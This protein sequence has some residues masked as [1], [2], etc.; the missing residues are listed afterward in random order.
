MKKAAKRSAKK[1]EQEAA[2]RGK[3]VGFVLECHR[4]GADHKVIE[5]VARTF[6]PD[7][8]RVYMCAGNKGLLFERCSR[9][10]EGLFEAERCDHVFVVWDLIPCDDEYRHAGKPSCVKERQHLLGTLRTEDQPKTVLLCITQELDSW[11]LADGAALAAVMSRPTHPL[12]AFADHKRPE[13]IANPKAILKQLFDEHTK[14][15]YDDLYH[16][17]KIIAAVQ[18]LAKLDRAPSFKRLREK[19]QSL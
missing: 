6:R 5:H 18:N 2:P 11:L 7:L 19:L 4:D 9:I 16:A 17:V 13:D 15:D 3:K 14:Y 10:V 1:A 8:Q 12:K